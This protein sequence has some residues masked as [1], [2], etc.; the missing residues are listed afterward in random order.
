M[1]RTLSSGGLT[2]DTSSSNSLNV[3]ALSSKL[4]ALQHTV[5]TANLL[6]ETTAAETAAE[7]Q[8]ALDIG[9][10]KPIETLQQFFDWFAVMES[11][12]EK[13][14]EDVYRNHLSV[15]E[16][17]KKA[18]DEFLEDL[19]STCGLFDELEKDYSFVD[20]QTCSIQQAC[21]T[22][23]DQQNSLTRLADGLVER[24]YYFNQLEPIAKLFNTPGEDIC[25]NEEFIPMLDKLDECISYMQEHVKWIYIFILI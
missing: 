18:C 25:L 3:N 8:S 7:K 20:I 12:M 14:Q 1:G 24:L 19:K 5:S 22:L 16:I 17:Y 15:V 13:G 10:S 2:P 11:E 21:E 23:L 4:N 6:A 9:S